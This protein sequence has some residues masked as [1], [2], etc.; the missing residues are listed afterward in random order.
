MK[1][2]AF[3]CISFLFSLF[4]SEDGDER[5]KGNEIPEQ[6]SGHPDEIFALLFFIVR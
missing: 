3:N 1:E 2:K 6:L 5:E 4:S